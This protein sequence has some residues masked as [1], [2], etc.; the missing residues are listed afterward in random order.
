MRVD[1]GALLPV[2]TNVHLPVRVREPDNLTAAMTMTTTL[3]HQVQ[4]RVTTVRVVYGNWYNHLGQDRPGPNVITVSAD[5]EIRGTRTAVTFAGDHW[6]RIEPGGAVISDPV[7]VNLPKAGHLTS[8]TTVSATA[9]GRIPLGPQTNADDG[10]AAVAGPP[11]PAASTAPS[12]AYGYG[13]WQLL[14]AAGA[15]TPGQGSPATVLVTGDSNAVGFG[16]RRGTACH[17]G[18]VRR[19]LD[20]RVPVVNLAVS[21]ATARG[22]L[23]AASRRRREVLLQW[24]RPELAVAA[25]GTNDLQGGGPELADMQAMLT[26][27]WRELVDLGAEVV[28][29]TLPPVTFSR[30]GW[31]SVAGQTPDAGREV[32]ARVNAWIRSVPAPLAGVVDLAGALAAPSEPDRWASGLTD[33]GLHPNA[34][35]HAA[36]AAAVRAPG[37]VPLLGA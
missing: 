16:D 32:R 10:E 33:D 8:R 11:P 24:V 15:P 27:H 4:R 30:D 35:G 3:R 37:V 21:G 9:A 20:G 1:D 22:A 25:L 28:A 7:P 2:G 14:A 29:C 36:A 18:W 6:V 5:I 19:A 17:L 13:P 12:T 34:A 31:R 23:T 26:A